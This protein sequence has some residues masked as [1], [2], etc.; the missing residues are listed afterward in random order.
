MHK[1]TILKHAINAV[2]Q[3]VDVI[4]LIGLEGFGFKNPQQ[5]PTMTR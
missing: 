5:L 4:I 2:K 1:I 3:G